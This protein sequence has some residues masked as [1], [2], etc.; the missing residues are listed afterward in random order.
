MRSFIMTK[1]K[2]ELLSDDWRDACRLR[3]CAKRFKVGD[4]V[5]ESPYTGAL[6]H[7]ECWTEP[8]PAQLKELSQDTDKLIEKWESEEE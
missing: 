5:V 6:F 2:L 4:R 3:K 8:S 7:A 1:E